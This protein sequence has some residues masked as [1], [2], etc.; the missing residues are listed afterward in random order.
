MSPQFWSPALSTAPLAHASADGTTFRDNNPHVA[1]VSA[2]VQAR[3][4]RRIGIV[5]CGG[6]V[7]LDALPWQNKS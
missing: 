4:I 1:G 3:P 6:N 2:E 7:E 5:L